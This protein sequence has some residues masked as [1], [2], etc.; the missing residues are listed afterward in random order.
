MIDKQ[1]TA[2][3]GGGIGMAGYLGLRSWTR[4]RLSRNVVIAGAKP[5]GPNA[6]D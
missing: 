3:H 1:T 5:D 4:L 2:L 6:D